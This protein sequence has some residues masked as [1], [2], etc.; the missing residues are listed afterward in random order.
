MIQSFF[1]ELDLPLSFDV[2]LHLATLLAVI[3]YFRR[4]ILSLFN[5]FNLKTTQGK[6][7]LRLIILLIIATIPAGIIG[8]VFN[9]KIEEVFKNPILVCIAWLIM[10]IVLI[11]SR[12]FESKGEEGKELKGLG[13]KGAILIGLAQA[14][15]ILPGIS[16]SGSTILAGL[17]CKLKPQDA[18]RF[19]FL[20]AIPVILGSA[21][22]TMR[23]AH[24]GENLFAYLL[25]ALLAAIVGYLSIILLI[26][27]LKQHLFF[28]FGVYLIIISI[29]GLIYLPHRPKEIYKDTAKTDLKKADGY[30]ILV[31]KGILT[32][33]DIR[34]IGKSDS[35]IAKPDS[36]FYKDPSLW[37]KKLKEFARDKKALILTSPIR[38]REDVDKPSSP[39]HLLMKRDLFSI[40][41]FDDFYFVY[42]PNSRLNEKPVE[43]SIYKTLIPESAY[44]FSET[45][46]VQDNS[47]VKEELMRSM[48]EAKGNARVKEYVALTLGKLG[49]IK[50]S[51][52]ILKELANEFPREPR[53][54][55]NLGVSYM[56]ERDYK[57]AEDPLKKAY[58]L[59]KKP[60]YSVALA[61]CYMN[62]NRYD[63]AEDVLSKESERGS[64]DSQGYYIWGMSLYKRGQYPPALEKV[65]KSLELDKKNF[66]SEHLK[67]EIQKRIMK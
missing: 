48:D 12:F 16:R 45:V 33:A 64:L 41:Y 17:G 50:E 38:I 3:V 40:V 65:E 29:A 7:A 46:T 47:S 8:K 25:A 51:A 42:V 10:G 26:K 6:E 39:A 1:P 63:D 24:W 27:L 56:R 20:M 66:K 28:Y 30:L 61:D 21:I 31:K 53:F 13:I 5:V 2:L 62:M 49:Y 34:D 23:K 58:I 43:Q 4:D 54:Y 9:D 52:S 44:L 15:A 60:Q 57:S 19:S 37:D 32:D 14:I 59:D 22:L 67:N 11:T 36:N 18:A 55:F 35:R